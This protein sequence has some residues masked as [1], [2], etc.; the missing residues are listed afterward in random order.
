M[1]GDDVTN[2]S[3]YPDAALWGKLAGTWQK[4]TQS[5]PYS[6]YVVN[7]DEPQTAFAYAVDNN[8]N[9]GAFG[10]CYTNATVENKR[11]IEDLK[12]LVNEINSASKSSIA[13]PK[14]LVVGEVGMTLDVHAVEVAQPQV[15]V[16]AEVKA[17]AAAPVERVSS[18]IR[19]FYL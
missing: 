9:P 14:S 16:K 7:W 18:Y 6:F 15:E 19:P 17:E 3:A 8:G 2:T 12:T 4:I 10:R 5:Q 11:N 13:L 1:A